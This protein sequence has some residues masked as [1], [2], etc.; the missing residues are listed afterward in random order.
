[1]IQSIILELLSCNKRKWWSYPPFIAANCTQWF[2][3]H[4]TLLQDTLV[5][6]DA[7]RRF[8][9]ETFTKNLNKSVTVTIGDSAVTHTVTPE[10]RYQRR[11]FQV[12]L[13]QAISR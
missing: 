8:S 11:D 6:L 2:A 4:Y 13:L 1:M 3:T 9:E 5:A 12:S 10:N 7:L